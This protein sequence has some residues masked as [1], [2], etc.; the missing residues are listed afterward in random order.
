MLSPC[1]IGTVASACT[2]DGAQVIFM[3]A[4]SV[5][6][7]SDIPCMIGCALSVMVYFI[8]PAEKFRSPCFFAPPTMLAMWTVSG[9][10]SESWKLTMP[11]PRL[12]NASSV[13][14]SGS[15]M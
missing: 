13:A 3:K 6:V 4:S 2:P 15:V 11:P 7:K 14:R 8:S 5:R 12:T 1:G 9:P 10:Q